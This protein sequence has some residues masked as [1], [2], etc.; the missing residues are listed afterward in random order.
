M[1]N[2]GCNELACEEEFIHLAATDFLCQI[3]YSLYTSQ[4]DTTVTYPDTTRE[5]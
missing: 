2:M 5:F 1:S 4:P 3:S